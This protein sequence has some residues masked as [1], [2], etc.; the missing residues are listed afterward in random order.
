MSAQSVNGYI[1]F[2]T[3]HHEKQIVNIIPLLK[4]YFT[5][6]ENSTATQILPNNSA[7]KGQIHSDL[8]WKAAAAVLCFA[9]FLFLIQF[10]LL[11]LSQV[12]HLMGVQ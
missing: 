1:I 5:M 11:F 6:Q 2:I 8:D 4:S 9:V 7:K 10:Y 3:Y 12:W